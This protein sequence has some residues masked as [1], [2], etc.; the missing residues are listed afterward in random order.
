MVIV[1]VMDNRLAA[2]NLDKNRKSAAVVHKKRPGFVGIFLKMLIIEELVVK[3]GDR[4][5]KEAK[6]NHP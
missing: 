1:V 3:K 4:H 5:A 2:Y 6:G